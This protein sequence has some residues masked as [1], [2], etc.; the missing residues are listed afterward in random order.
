VGQQPLAPRT[1]ARRRAITI[2]ESLV[3][4]GPA[5]SRP[6]VE[7]QHI[8]KTYGSTKALDDVS[9]TV[10]EGDSHALVGRNG[11]GKSTLV[12]ILTGLQRPDSGTVSFGG[13]P[14][15]DISDRDGW[16]QVVACVYQKSTII[17]GLSVAENLFLN[18]QQRGPGG[19]INWRALNKAAQAL[20]DEWD[21]RIDVERPAAELTV[22]Q[23]QMVEIARALSFGARFI[24]LDEPTAQL[25]SPGIQRLFTR[26]RDIQAHGV[27][28]LY[29]SH[30]LEEIY[31]ICQ[32]VTVFRDARHVL[33]APVTDLPKNDLVSAMTGEA[34]SDRADLVPKIAPGPPVLRVRNLTRTGF[35]TDISFDISP[36]EVVGITGS[37]SSG[38]ITLAETIVGLRKATSG[39]VQVAGVSPKPGNVTSAIESGLGFVPR[40]RHHEGY[41]PFLSVAE[42]ATM[43]VTRQLGRGGFINLK[44]RDDLARDLVQNLSIVTS[45]PDQEVGSLSGGNQQKVVMARALANNPRVLVLMH[46]TAGVDVRSKETLLDVVDE[47]RATG[48]GVLIVSDELE[49]LRPCDRVL[50]MLHG[51]V[52]REFPHG[53]R[54]TEII[55]AIEGVG[56]DR[57]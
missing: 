40:D 15:P 55:A 49:D 43:T 47:R 25:D 22:E 2:G 1:T 7:A 36:G 48:T 23:R 26:V 34:T 39:S 17:P 41:V 35:F 45:G 3:S 38:R 11:A 12:S 19:A 13:A 21:V 54:D 37:G 28:L 16:R 42:N 46:P 57:D 31:E 33:T 29:I 24:I 5:L 4:G 32:T 6:A 44:H 10:R 30:H 9:L 8:K 18:R 20:L 51:T 53:W 56:S 27:T 52:V 50:V 14:A